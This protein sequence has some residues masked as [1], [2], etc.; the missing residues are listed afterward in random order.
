[1]K[2]IENP[3]YEVIFAKV[4]NYIQYMKYH[5]VIGKFMD[6]WPLDKSLIW[7]IN[8]KWK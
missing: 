2:E 8:S 5:E 7:W 1:V 6:I 4:A 3:K